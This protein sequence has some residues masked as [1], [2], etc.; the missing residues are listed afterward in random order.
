MNDGSAPTLDVANAVATITLRRPGH[1]NRIDPDDPG[2]LLRHLEEVRDDPSV[3]LLVL[4]GEGEKT[5]CSGYTLAEIGTRLDRSF[6]DMVDSLEALEIPTL[7]A[8]NGSAYGGGIDLALACD[9]RIAFHG[10]RLFMPAARFGLHYYPGGLRRFVTR[11]GCSAAKKILLT[12]MTLESE[13]LLRI[14]FLSELVE[15]GEFPQRL[16]M[17]RDHIARCEAQAV[18]SMKRHINAI[19]AGEWEEASGR[20]AYERSLRAPETIERLRALAEPSRATPARCCETPA[21]RT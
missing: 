19:S 15:R 18:R 12:G 14:G 13:E 16:T 2:V 21:P 1:H 4:T 8:L 10:C 6:E 9:L 3:R 11:L 7:C 17:Y 5:F 20:A